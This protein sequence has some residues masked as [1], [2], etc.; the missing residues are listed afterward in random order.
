[1]CAEVESQEASGSPGFLARTAQ[2]RVRVHARRVPLDAETVRPLVFKVNSAMS[3]LNEYLR[4][5]SVTY[6]WSSL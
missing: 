3:E 6:I 1:V 2:G 4:H 5:R